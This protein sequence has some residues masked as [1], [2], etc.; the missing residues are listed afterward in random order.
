[1][2]ALAAFL[3]PERV[4]KAA[5]SGTVA[6]AAR[7]AFGRSI[8][9]ALVTGAARLAFTRPI[10]WTGVTTSAFSRSKSAFARGKAI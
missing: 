3:A 1:L 10:G 6:R 7:L 5:G 4:R 9:W 8:G 2:R